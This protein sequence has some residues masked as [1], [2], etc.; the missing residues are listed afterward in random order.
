MIERT[1]D[2][3]APRG[4]RN[5]NPGN[6]KAASSFVWREQKG[7]DDKGFCIFSSPAWGIRAICLIWVAYEEHHGCSSLRD[8][9]FRWAPPI[10]NE[11][12]AYLTYMAKALDVDPYKPLDIHALTVPIL[13]ALTHYECG[14]QPYSD[15][16]FARGVML[17]H[18]R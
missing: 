9:I 11:T 7:A 2:N 15:T 18:E 12:S 4:I 14:E 8:Y 13:K 16:V 3:S 10:E 5:C 17:S 6:I 1:T